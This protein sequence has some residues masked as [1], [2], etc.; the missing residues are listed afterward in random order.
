MNI[1]EN[2]NRIINGKA[3]IR[4]SIIGKGVD[5]PESALIDAYSEY[6]D[7]IEQG[8]GGEDVGGIED[9]LIFEIHST[10][11]PNPQLTFNGIY[12]GAKNVRIST[13]NGSTWHIVNPNAYTH[14]FDGHNKVIFRYIP[15][16]DVSGSNTTFLTDS[17]SLYNV[18]GYLRN[19]STNKYQYSCFFNGFRGND[20][21]GLTIESETFSEYACY[22]MFE[23]STI[24]SAPIIKCK[25]AKGFSFQAMFKNCANLVDVHTIDVLNCTGSSTMDTMFY[26]CTS[27]INA[28]EINVISLKSSNGM[29]YMFQNCTSLVNPPSILKPTTLY[30]SC[31]Y[32]MFSGCSSLIE[33]P[34]LPAVQ[35][36][37]GAYSSMFQNCT[38]IQRVKCYSEQIYNHSNWLNGAKQDGVFECGY[39]TT[40]RTS[41]VG[42]V[43]STMSVERKNRFDENVFDIVSDEE[44]DVDVTITIKKNLNEL[45]N[46]YFSYSTDGGENWTL[47]ET[48]DDFSTTIKGDDVLKIRGISSIPKSDG[49]NVG[50]SI[51][52]DSTKFK[53]SGD[54]YAV[55]NKAFVGLFKNSKITEANIEFHGDAIYN[56]MCYEMFYGCNELKTAPNFGN[57]NLL[58]DYGLYCC[59]HNCFKLENVPS[60]KVNYISGA[61]AM[62]Y[63][64]SYCIKLT[65]CNM[66]VNVETLPSTTCQYMCQYCRSLEK[67]PKIIAKNVE[68]GVF[69]SAFNNCSELKNIDIKVS[70]INN[71]NAF[72]ST[73]SNC[74]SLVDASNFVIEF[75]TNWNTFILAFDGCTSLKKSPKMNFKTIADRA[76]EN[77]FRNC[78]SLEEITLMSLQP[79][80]SK[81]SENWMKNVNPNPITFYLNADETWSDTIVRGSSTLPSNAIIEHITM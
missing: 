66:I 80:S 13:D 63:M 22:R 36:Q 17:V 62:G 28:P 49:S 71:T 45:P 67:T 69:E 75:D 26:G 21:S 20:F 48:A 5:V 68:N 54:I 12:I 23:N 31:Y 14:V 50:Y 29:R 44:P 46:A 33:S 9:E 78:T 72:Y 59:F 70:N 34:M 2:L 24:V 16:K 41:G 37:S 73:F 76:L 25:E 1:G 8:G 43:P 18:S 42:G 40:I 10:T 61:I 30:S 39:Y 81:V 58:L 51:S 52:S 35:Y 47:H 6:I 56:Y 32:G 77:M 27:L 15:T 19:A 3:S 11:I 60:F 74:T 55:G 79:L 57:I 65:D 38:S 7:A 53:V 64:F 4:Q